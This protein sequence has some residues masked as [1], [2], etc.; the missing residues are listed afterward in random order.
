M[1]IF[2]SIAAAAFAAAATPASAGMLD[3]AGL[4]EDRA[5]LPGETLIFPE[6]EVTVVGSGFEGTE[7]GSL[8]S[9]L[10]LG[11]CNDAMGTEVC[12]DSPAIDAFETI[13]LFFDDFRTIQ[14]VVFLDTQGND[15]SDSMG[16]IV[17]V[18]T[19]S[20]SVTGS[21]SA[22]SAL[23]AAGDALFADTFSFGLTALDATDLFI[24]SIDINADVIPVPAALPLLLSGLAGLGFASR[25]RKQAAEA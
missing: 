2:L 23:I 20:G 22:I 3:F 25:R 15:V 24:G 5:L 7:T 8:S 19:D 17:E 13:D 9:G 18:F 4:G 12:D 10:G 1:K 16:L 14:D 11:V 21:L 6:L